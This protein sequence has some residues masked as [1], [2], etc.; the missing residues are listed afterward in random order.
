MLRPGV[1]G[2]A[3]LALT[4]DIKAKLMRSRSMLET[5]CEGTN[6][7]QARF[8]PQEQARIKR[9]WIGESIIATYDKKIYHVKD[10]LFDNSP[11]SL[12]IE[13]LGM[14]HADYFV[15]RKGLD[16]QY[17]N[18]KLMV[19]VEG[20][21]DSTIFIPP[22][23]VCGVEIEPFVK[24]QLPMLTS[25]KPKVR[26]DAINEIKRFLVP[27]AQKT[28]GK[29]GLLPALGIILKEDRL[30]VKAETAPLPQIMAAGIK[31]SY[32]A[33]VACCS[34]D[35]T[36]SVLCRRPS[37]SGWSGFVPSCLSSDGAL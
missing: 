31:V 5:I 24:Q 29:G 10:L 23:L 6:P 1:G 30:A 19:A 17:P 16:I 8:S 13:G 26:N 4:V 14:S 15:K 33:A 36:A 35:G 34:F 32:S 9:Q 28:K 2:P 25:Y 37:S 18:V 3:H 11:A 7:N 27:G 12:P 21:R 22:E 20:R